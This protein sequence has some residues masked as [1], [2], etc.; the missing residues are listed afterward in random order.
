MQWLTS[1]LAALGWF[2]AQFTD[3]LCPFFT[4]LCK[5]QTFGWM[6]DCKSTFD[7]IKHYLIEPLILSSL[8]E[9]EELY[10]YLAISN[11]AVSVVLFQQ[12]QEDG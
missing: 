5:A 1:H 8:E 10:M 4:T 6:E 11:H 2:I 9:V 12:A 3:K 7:A